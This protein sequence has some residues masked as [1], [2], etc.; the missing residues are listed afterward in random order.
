MASS[1]EASIASATSLWSAICPTR[2][3]T[4][5]PVTSESTP[6]AAC[7][8]LRILHHSTVYP[9]FDNL[10]ARRPALARLVRG[11]AY[12]FEKTPLLRSCGLSHLLVVQKE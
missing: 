12:T 6:G 1:G 7:A 11:V 3:G 2:C 8:A 4:D 10:A 5:W 9:G